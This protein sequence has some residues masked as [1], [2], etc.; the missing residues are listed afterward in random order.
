MVFLTTGQIAKE[1]GEDRDRVSYAIR[2]TA[3]KPIG[4]AG[5][6]RLFGPDAVERVRQFLNAK[7]SHRIKASILRHSQ[8]YALRPPRI[9]DLRQS[10]HPGRGETG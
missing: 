8:R 5:M 4:R 10:G 2:K 6:V 3:L 9:D 7:R 1:I